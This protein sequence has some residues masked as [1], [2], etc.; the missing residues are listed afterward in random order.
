MSWVL[1]DTSS[2]KVEW[3]QQQSIID[4]NFQD[5]N[6]IPK[7]E[8]QGHEYTSPTPPPP[9]H[10]THNGC[11]SMSTSAKTYQEVE[12]GRQVH[13][14]SWKERI[15]LRLIYGWVES[16]EELKSLLTREKEE[17]EKAGL[18]L[19]IQKLR[20]STSLELIQMYSF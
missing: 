7:T 1:L 14:P 11:T 2:H 18:K 20:S 10:I 8:H 3:T 9:P 19:N 4:R 15:T 12:L 6:G 5:R 16:E 17:S 13:T